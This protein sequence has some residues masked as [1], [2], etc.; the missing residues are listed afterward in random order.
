MECLGTLEV[1]IDVIFPLIHGANGEDGRLQGMLDFIGVPY[2]G[3]G[4]SGSVICMDKLFTKAI[5][6][7]IGIRQLPYVGFTSFDW[8]LS[9]DSIILEIES[10]GYPIFIKPANL[11]SSIGI[12]KVKSRESLRRAI[13]DALVYDSRILAEKGL[14]SPREIEFS[15]L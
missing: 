5:L 6:D 8:K 15:V 11:G 10:L 1:K 3:S 12:T 4:V 2:I 14:E 9:S 7:K 13:E